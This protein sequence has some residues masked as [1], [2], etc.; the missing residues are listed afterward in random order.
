M[1]C[2]H[3]GAA[4]ADGSRFCSGCGGT[5]T[6]SI[7][8][9]NPPPFAAETEYGLPVG[10]ILA[11]RYQILGVLGM[12]GMGRV[13]LAED[14]K[15]ETHVAIK[16]L[17]EV[18]SRDPGSVKRLIA[19]AN[20]SMMLS[21]PNVVRVHN[22]EDGE[23]VKFLIMEYV[24]G[25]TLAKRIADQGKLAEAEAR[26][27]AIGTC[28]GLEH[29]H[30]Q[31]VIHRDIKPGNILLGTSGAI[32]LAD[33]GIARECRDS[34]SHLTSQ[35]DSGTLLYM[36]P[37]QLLGKSNES[38]DAYSLGVVLYE[39]LAG[40]PPF[41]TG[42]I[43]LQIREVVPD[44]PEGISP[45][46]SSIVLKCLEKNPERR[47]PS[48]RALREELDGTAE[49]RRKEEA[50]AA[51][52]CRIEEE[53][54][55][56]EEKRKAEEA[57]RRAE[58]QPR[59]EEQR[60]QAE[61][62]VRRKAEEARAA[63]LRRA[64]L[65]AS[66][67]KEE[68]QRRQEEVRH[69][70]EERKTAAAGLAA[71]ALEFLNRGAFDEAET[72]LRE[73]LSLDP[74]HAE[75]K[76][77]LDRCRVEKRAAE[78]R[79]RQAQSPKPAPVVA[80]PNYGRNGGIGILAVAIIAVVIWIAT[81]LGSKQQGTPSSGPATE[82]TNSASVDSRTNSSAL[83][84][85]QFV[86]IPAGK[87]TMGCSAGDGQ[88]Y[89]HESP[90]HEVT[91]SRNFEL[92][93]YEV[94]QG[95]WIKVMGNNPSN[96]KG[97]DRLPVEQVSWNDTQAFIAKLNALD[98]GYRYRLPTEAEWEYAA[99]AGTT[100]PQYGNLDGIAW[101]TSNSGDKT[102]P[103]GQKQANGFGLYDMLGNVWEWCQ[104]WYD[105]QY[106]A[107]SPTGDPKG[108]SSG[109]VRVLRGGSWSNYSGHARVSHRGKN[110]P[111]DGYDDIGFRVC[112]EKL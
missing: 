66:R 67:R 103:I 90:R 24:E 34:V 100:G 18:L 56:A 99:R 23:L 38:T 16:V 63:E 9:K 29:A 95:Q 48:V 42:D 25:E 91:I 76:A 73:A 41:R 6:S 10:T 98:V 53:R 87:F 92:G 68:E 50:R 84:E 77:A 39:M 75:A 43:T 32:K 106:Y 45:E 71:A 11:N 83:S 78:L 85:L 82:Q 13:Y 12:G 57:Q 80:K 101:Y 59:A 46:L 72:N 81:S 37:E 104:D 70:E 44:P 64:E 14:Q 30:E 8:G 35:V 97:D 5:I 58:E 33:F 47:F 7:P 20:H 22:F 52:L 102:H 61:L 27:I 89:P 96:F 26:R 60:R 4:N 36:S 1:F 40:Q 49:T 79:E 74:A 69:R 31:K 3:C 109:Q 107:G 86:S 94:T 15:R 112:R 62:E 88:C 108:P 28:L 105:E 65:E 55:R 111:D 54:L 51:D 19:E 110:S 2:N 93:K 17:R 21:H